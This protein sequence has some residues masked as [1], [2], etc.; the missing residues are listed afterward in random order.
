MKTFIF[1]I[2]FVE[3]HSEKKDVIA[4]CLCEAWVKLTSHYNRA[5]DNV[6]KRVQVPAEIK[7]LGQDN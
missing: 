6:N 5:F 3:G 1:E 7:Y 2:K 4:N